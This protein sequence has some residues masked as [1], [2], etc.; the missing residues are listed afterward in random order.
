M[1]VPGVGP[2]NDEDFDNT[3]LTPLIVTPITLGSPSTG[4][5]DVGNSNVFR[6]TVCD[7][8]PCVPLPAV[9]VFDFSVPLAGFGG[10]WDLSVGGAGGGLDLSTNVG[11]VGATALSTTDGFSG[12]V[13]FVAANSGEYFT[14]LTVGVDN[15]GEDFET[16]VLD[17]AVLAPVPIPAAAWLLLSG[18]AG[19]VGLGRRRRAEGTAEA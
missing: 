17:D 6:D 15:L 9:T 13:G 19:F 3:S 5:V 12:F 10:N 16:Y 7:A 18:F 8:A 14:Q 11:S 1:A 4:G 2:I